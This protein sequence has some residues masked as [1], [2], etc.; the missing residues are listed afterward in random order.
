[1]AYKSN[2][3]LQNFETYSRVNF[4]VTKIQIDHENGELPFFYYH[5]FTNF[6]SF[7]ESFYVFINTY[8]TF[9]YVS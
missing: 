2:K 5:I 6:Y 1:M 3:N 7:N 8:T 9:S 4:C